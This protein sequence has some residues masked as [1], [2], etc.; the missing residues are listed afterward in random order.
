MGNN[1]TTVRASDGHATLWTEFLLLG[2]MHTTIII[3]CL[4]ATVLLSGIGLYVTLAGPQND[5]A[6][7]YAK[8]ALYWLIHYRGE[9]DFTGVT[10]TPQVVLS[11]VWQKY[12][13]DALRVILIFPASAIVCF[14]G[15]YKIAL[16]IFRKRAAGQLEDTVIRGPQ[17]ST[18]KDV[19]KQMKEA[20]QSGD[21]HM[22]NVSMPRESEVYHTLYGGSTGSGKSTAIEQA[23]RDK[24]GKYKIVFYDKDGEYLQKFYNPE[25]D[26]IFNPLDV[27]CLKWNVFN[28]FETEMDI[29]SFTTSMIPQAKNPDSNTAFFQNGSRDALVG[30]LHDCY[31]KGRRTNKDIWNFITTPVQ[32][33]REILK[34]VQGAEAALSALGE[35]RDS[36]QADGIQGVLMQYCHC[37]KY[38]TDMEG[39]FSLFKWLS[40]GKPGTLFISNYSKVRDTLR[41]ILSLFID[42]LG[43]MMDSLPVDV[44]RRVYFVLDEL[45]TLQKLPI[46]E[47]LLT[48]S[49]KK[50]SAVIA[51]I[52]DFSQLDE[53]YGS[54]MRKTIVNCFNSTVALRC[55]DPDTSKVF[56][57]RIGRHDVLKK[58]MNTSYGAGENRDGKTISEHEKPEELLVTASEIQELKNFQCYIKIVEY[59][60]FLDKI[61]ARWSEKKHEAFII[62]PGLSLVEIAAA[63]QKIAAAAEQ[64][65]V[66]RGESEDKKKSLNDRLRTRKQEQ[67]Q[68][69]ER[70]MM[71]DELENNN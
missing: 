13:F 66:R 5:T 17:L 29:D 28:E 51:G 65:V 12:K 68:E 52:Q 58:R 59:P 42:R 31:Q 9:A 47:E 46:I 25:K 69:Q 45:D 64:V 4:I 20:G 37:F 61:P 63:Q 11:I 30:G 15:G 7:A 70:G 27:R 49:R 67:E 10:A 38:L 54:N 18:A 35:A 16:S 57:E 50:G 56:A 43:S 53:V 26:L 34:G 44:N 39:D 62:R 8:A 22:G 3:C 71:V 23:I 1:A 2:N 24:I 33:K 60:A 6:R 40:D 14:V 48:Q 32:K 21:M 41:P 55:V 19:A 36:K